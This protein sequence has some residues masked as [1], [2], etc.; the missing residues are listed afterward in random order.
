MAPRQFQDHFSS[1]APTYRKYR[2]CYPRELSAWLA[3]QAPARELAV[4]IASGN[5]QAA[6]G[7]AEFFDSVIATEPSAAQLALAEPHPRVSYRREP[8]ERISLADGSADLIVAA[9]AAHWFSW[10]EFV[11]EVRRVL[12][13][14]GLL[15]VWSYGLFVTEPAIDRLIEDFY[16][17]VVGPHWPRAR[18]HVEEGYRDLPLPLPG[19]AT[20]RFEMRVDWDRETVLGYLG[21]W[22]AVERYRALRGRDPL[23][24]LTPPL[25]E[26]W[27]TAARPV[28]WR[29]QLKTGRA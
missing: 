11:D 20:P 27:G 4:D 16:R 21:S 6:T 14:G 8:A 26:A 17:V 19:C 24:L 15:A 25:A 9:Q 1:Q 3:A 13:P 28:R 22:S 10:P 12:R 7:L 5:G 18:R 2:P 23:E 29:L